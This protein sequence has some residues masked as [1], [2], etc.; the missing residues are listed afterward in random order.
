MLEN[1]SESLSC[2][3]RSCSVFRVCFDLSDL[4]NGS[5]EILMTFQKYLYEHFC[6]IDSANKSDLQNAA[7]RKEA[8]ARLFE[9]FQ[10]G[11][12]WAQGRQCLRRLLEQLQ[13]VEFPLMQ[14]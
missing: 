10:V 3:A 6:A 2:H 1:R 7:Y 4:G 13:Q 12:G 11:L 8:G 9:S 5:T 14:R